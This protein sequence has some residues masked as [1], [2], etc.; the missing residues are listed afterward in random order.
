CIFLQHSAQQ[1]AAMDT[2]DVS[3]IH[4]YIQILH[5]QKRNLKAAEARTGQQPIDRKT[6]GQLIEKHRLAVMQAMMQQLQPNDH[7]VHSSF[8]PPPYP[9]STATLESLTPIFISELRLGTHHRGK[10]IL[11]RSATGPA[12][13]TAIINVIEDEREDAVVMQLY[14]QP[15]EMIRPASSIATTGDVFLIK[16]PFFKVMVDGEYGLRI[17][18][19][20]DLVRI[21][22]RHSLC[23]N[24]WCPRLYDLDKAA[25]DW[26][27]E[28]NVAMGLKKHWEAIESYTIALSSDPSIA[29]ERI[30]RLN[31][32]LAYLQDENF[33][34]AL[35]DTQCLSPNPNTSEKTLYRGAKAL[36]GLGRFSECCDLLQTLRETYPGNAQ[37]PRDLVRARV[38][39]S[40]Q[41]NGT[42][43]FKAIYKEV[44]K[45][46]PPLLDHAT[47]IGPIVVK[48][49]PG[50]GRGL[51]T[52]K[53]VKAGELLLCE[54]AFAHCYAGDSDEESGGSSKTKLLINTHTNRMSIGSQSD[55]I[56]LIVQK[57][58][59]NAS[60]LTEFVTLHHGSYEHSGVT[61]VDGKPVV[62]S[63]LVERIIALNG[64]GSPLT[65]KESHLGIRDTKN[66]FGSCG[67]WP[68]ASRINHCC[69]SNVRR[70]F[71]GDLQI[72][73]ATCDISA[74]TELTFWYKNPTGDHAE[75]QKGLEQWGFQCTCA[76]CLDSKNTSKKVLKKRNGLLGD[77]K[78]TLE[79]TNIDTS[80]AERILY[81]I[82]QTYKRPA[83]DV[84]RLALREPYAHLA[85]LYSN[86]RNAE[87]AV[88]M[89]LKALESLG[90]VIKGAQL[91]ISPTE[92]FR[93]EKLG[94]MAGGVVSLWVHLWNAYSARAPH[95][96][97]Q[98]DECTR[99]AYKICV[100][101]DVTFKESYDKDGDMA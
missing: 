16:E 84:P 91:P 62:D 3:D 29:E 14:Q 8:L 81:A 86:Q 89:A 72:V 71:I 94:T 30:I 32:A 9:P 43:D 77:L 97:S 64:F 1:K 44:S 92:T 53:A 70:S 56:T 76:M 13:M 67:V 48:P 68:L 78:A 41:R 54:K 73:R 74:D 31:R 37:A 28:G 69:T 63:F 85:L 100:G 36:Y 87:K 22:T 15:E 58:Q 96:L 40:E 19:V 2:N 34:A 24:K 65:S 90:F 33:E 51:Y 35:A 61:E 21:D 4:Q 95:L 11:V 12:R 26:K 93:V 6:R 18:H 17:D 55:L 20:S 99:L 25:D 79:V 47:F 83:S 49:S 45:L 88:A 38:R 59:R 46:R 50:R 52:T 57:L 7:Q 42:Y 82:G 80:K 27:Q 10:Y 5:F 98:V 39:L 60:L 23:P 101:E 66:T 75:M